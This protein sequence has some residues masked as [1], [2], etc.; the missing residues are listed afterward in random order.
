VRRPLTVVQLLP[1]LESGGVERST[2]EIGRALVAAGHRSWVVSAGGRLA[3]QLQ[4]EGSSHIT[5]AIGAKSPATL[6]RVAALRW[7]LKEVAPDIVHARSRLPAWLARA[8]LWRLK[9]HPN[10]VTTAHGL[11][12]PG[13]YSAVMASGERVICVSDSVRQ[14]LL[15]HYPKVDAARMEVIP[16]GIDPDAFPPGLRTEPEWRADFF[17]TFPT[18][19]GGPILT[20]SG[21]GTRLKGHAEAIHL[22]AALAERGSAA[23]LLLMGAVEA[24]RER[25]L[26]E[27]QQLAHELGVAARLAISPARADMAAVYAQSA[28]VLQLSNKPEAFG[29][30][31]V[32]A[33]HM[34]IP[35][36]GFD[37]GGVGELL[38]E[39]YPVGAVA[40]GD[41]D[42][43]L[44]SA[45]ALLQDAPPVMA[46]SHY[47]LADMQ[48][49]TLALYAELVESSA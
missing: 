12:S 9:P 2:L 49:A 20:L 18:L 14:H 35:V 44:D 19:R 4:A 40:L 46:F 22:L 16:R 26:G 25:Y 39:L 32:E 21:R 3:E 29:R 34:G 7:L 37:H 30:T 23:R 43:L 8:A 36:L 11:N 5:L 41:R 24:G 42:A 31:V 28:L 48:Q 17:E 38:R 15:R 45:L 1:A 33:L 47:R 27:L 6:M 13:R 10:F